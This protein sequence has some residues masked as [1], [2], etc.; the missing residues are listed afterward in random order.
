MLILSDHLS[1]EGT[2]AP[3]GCKAT[4]WGES[5]LNRIYLTGINFY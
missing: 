3:N 5:L 4:D 1:R 2:S